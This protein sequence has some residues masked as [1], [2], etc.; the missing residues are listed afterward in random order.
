MKQII[1]LNPEHISAYSLIIEEGTVFAKE[2][3]EGAPKEKELPNEE[4]ERYMYRCTEELLKNAGYHRY[5][6]SNYAKPGRECRHN[7]GY[8]ERKNYLGIGLGASG[9]IDNVRYKN[10][11]DLQKY[12][13]LLLLLL[14]LIAQM[15][16]WA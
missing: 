14:D 13:S 5:E 4:D 2:Y 11:E 3:G 6:I 10:T 1:E 9:L 8:W 12:L 16:F 15:I 7:L